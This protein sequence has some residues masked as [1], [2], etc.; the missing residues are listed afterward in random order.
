MP[1]PKRRSKGGRRD[2]VR[3]FSIRESLHR[4][5]LESLVPLARV[6]HFHHNLVTNAKQDLLHAFIPAFSH[7]KLTLVSICFIKRSRQRVGAV[8][9]HSSSSASTTT[10]AQ[11]FAGSLRCEMRSVASGSK[12]L[13]RAANG[14][15][16]TSTAAEKHSF[17]RVTRRRYNVTNAAAWKRLRSSARGKK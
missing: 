8:L 10:Y 13:G 6:L 3:Q 12:K 9:S 11:R 5:F 4:S 2:S 16:S 14:S 15:R 7:H 1:T 17:S